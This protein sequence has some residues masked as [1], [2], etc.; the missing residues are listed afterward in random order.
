MRKSAPDAETAK[1]TIAATDTGLRRE[2]IPKLAK[3]IDNQKIRTVRKGSEMPLP[4]CSNNVSRVWTRSTLTC[5]A[6]FL[7]IRWA[8][9]WVSSCIILDTT[10]CPELL[11]SNGDQLGLAD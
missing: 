11:A 4:A 10:F 3:I 5:I 8:S 9:L 6:Q 1:R 2:N 7:M